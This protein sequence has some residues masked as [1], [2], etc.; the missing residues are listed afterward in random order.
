MHALHQPSLHRHAPRL[1]TFGMAGNYLNK[2]LGLDRMAERRA[3]Q[4]Q[5]QKGHFFKHHCHFM[6]S[7]RAAI[8][9]L[10]PSSV[11]IL[12]RSALGRP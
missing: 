12:T 6:N 5:T 4:A 7:V 8:K 9:A 2:A 3:D 11:P 10:L 1:G